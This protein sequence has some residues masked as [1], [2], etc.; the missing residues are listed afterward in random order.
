VISSEKPL[1]A[2]HLDKSAV[3]RLRRF[4][5]RYFKFVES[6]ASSRSLWWLP[7]SDGHDQ[8]ESSQFQIHRSYFIALLPRRTGV[9]ALKK[10]REMKPSLLFLG[11]LIAGVLR[12]RG[13]REGGGVGIYWFAAGVTVRVDS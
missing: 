6:G 3:T 5:G 9:E 7:K 4:D 2:L 8:H 1:G 13:A 12:F 11:V 10:K